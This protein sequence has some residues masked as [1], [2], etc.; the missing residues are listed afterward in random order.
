VTALTLLA[1]AGNARAAEQPT[2]AVDNSGPRFAWRMPALG[3]QLI[4]E[5][6]FTGGN[7][8]A[9][10]LLSQA[11]RDAQFPD[12]G[13]G[14]GSAV[15]VW[16][17]QLNGAVQ[18]RRAFP[19]GSL[20]RIVDVA[21]VALAFDGTRVA[22]DAA[23]NATIVWLRV[24]AGKKQAQTRTLKADGSLT[25]VQGLSDAA[26]DATGSR[27]AIRPNGDATFVWRRNAIVQTRTRTASNGLLSAV[28]D[29]SAAG[30]NGAQADVGV[31]GAGNATFVWRRH[32]GANTVIATRRRTAAGALGAVKDLSS[33]GQNAIDAA[34][35][36]DANDD[37]A[38]IWRRDNGSNVLLAQ[39]TTRK[40]DGTFTKLQT[41]S[42]PGQNVTT[43]G[44]GIDAA[45]NATFA[46]ERFDGANSIAHA[47]RFT[48]A[49]ATYGATK[50]LSAAGASASQLGVGVAPAGDAFFAWARA[51]VI[52]ARRLTAADV[53]EPVL[54][55]QPQT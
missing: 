55:V 16:E 9:T 35:A 33:P 5:R 25:P 39:S 23:G 12:V 27:V 52:E 43:L 8:S 53:L 4:G 42:S 19:D 11:D 38:F 41:I 26:L 31:D 45:G 34:V 47:R 2:V 30:E 36:V 6:D 21:P 32:N 37:A 44:A 49:T 14:G 22:V 18:A 50:T 1:S 51:G 24:V 54:E 15:V 3:H 7:L 17:D 20:G 13:V 40:P 10:Q 48:A 28:Q 46:W 29:V